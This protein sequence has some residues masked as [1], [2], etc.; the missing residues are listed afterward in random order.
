MSNE[1]W[2]KVGCAV[3]LHQWTS[4]KVLSPEKCEEER[5]CKK[6]GII[7]KRF[8]HRWSDWDYFQEKCC[9]QQRNCTRCRDTEKRIA[10]HEWS[11]WA[12]QK[13]KDCAQQ[14][15]CQ[16]CG[17]VDNRVTHETQTVTFQV[18]G[19][20]IGVSVCPRCG[21]DTGIKLGFPNSSVV[22]CPNC[23]TECG[24]SGMFCASCGRSVR[25]RK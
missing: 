8:D 25:Q 10:K 17:L 21:G 1:F 6:C 19:S 23:G 3:Q 22:N 11:G 5:N 20:S 18:G 15:H 16:R 13:E 4:W 12:Y 9:D 24:K 7:A 14:N 2:N